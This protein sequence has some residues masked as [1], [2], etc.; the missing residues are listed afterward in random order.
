[1]CPKDV[2]MANLDNPAN[3]VDIPAHVEDVPA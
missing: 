1:M 3:V 2:G